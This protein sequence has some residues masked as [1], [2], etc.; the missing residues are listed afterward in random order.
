VA[1]LTGAPLTLPP[2]HPVAPRH[3][4]RLPVTVEATDLC[5]RFAG[6]IVR[7][8][9]P[10]AATPAWMAERLA[11]CGQRSVSPLVDISNYVMFECG[12][13]SH[14]FD[15]AKIHGGLTVRWGRPGEQLRLL[16]GN[17]VELDAQVGVIADDREV[18]SLAGIMGGDA[19]A[20]SDDTR[21]IYVE[22]AFWW[23]DA[24]AGRGRR[25]GFSTDA[26]HRF[27]R[28]VDP[29]GCVLAIERITALILEVCGGE[30]GPI[31]D[32][33]PAMPHPKPVTLRVARAAK[34][35]GMPVSQ[36]DCAGVMRKLGLAFEEGEGVLRVTPPSRRFDL[37]VEEDLI[38]EVIRVLGYDRLPA[39]PPRAPVTA[40]PQDE[41]RRSRHALRHAIAARDYQETIG[42]SFVEERWERELAG[43]HRPIRVLNPIAAPLAVMRSNLLGSLLQALRHNLARR[44]ERVR[45]FEVG[46]VFHRDPAAVDGPFSVA[47]VRQPMRVGGLAWG[48]AERLQWATKERHVDFFDVKGDVEALL[49][50]APVRFVPA[51][52]EAA[53]PAL[54]PGRAAWVEVDGQRV[55]FLG[56]LHPRWRLAYELPSAPVLFE[57]DLE[58]LLQRPLPAFQPLPKQLSTWR[59]LAVVA[60]QALPHDAVVQAI[61]DADPLLRSV[62]LFDVW[63]PA[64]P[65]ADIGPGE[66]SL[67]LRLELRDDEATLTDERIEAAVRR[68]ITQLSGLGARPRG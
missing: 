13:P 20:V 1:A 12:Q 59:D 56:E 11:R 42:F 27:E 54:H 50:P 44:A 35:I 31:D 55:G 43:N 51:A 57:L 29:E 8:V 3:D 16:N 48:P 58:A 7:G 64:Q 17:T 47:G 39:T 66:H 41:R 19:T 68:V 10:K 5:G 60:P 33:R 62:R 28:G 24:I 34:V 46:R 30:A 38:E 37:A 65:T 36:A 6:R 25:Y 23:P 67:A 40:L 49:T 22:A 63:Q 4:A 18:E 53:H 21:D 32:Q 14:I 52:G 26:G 45:L 15:L 9:N 61:V 2:V